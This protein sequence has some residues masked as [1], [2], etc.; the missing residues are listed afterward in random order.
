MKRRV[1]NQEILRDTA[2]GKAS[3]VVYSTLL[4]SIM[5]MEAAAS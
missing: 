4:Q 5:K 3:S 1:V 2:T